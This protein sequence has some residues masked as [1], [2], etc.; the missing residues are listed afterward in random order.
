MTTV[1]PF[2]DEP[3][4]NPDDQ[5]FR[6]DVEGYEGPLDVL[7]QL[8]RTEKID[9]TRVAI[10]PL[11]EQ[12]LAFIARA[13]DLKIELAADFLVMAAWLAWLKSRLIAPDPSD[14]GADAEMLAEDLAFRLR[15]LE[16][17]REAAQQLFSRPLLGQGVFARGMPERGTVETTV[18]WRASLYDLL[19]AYGSV[20]QQEIVR[21][22]KMEKRPVFSIV[23]A[24]QV[25]ERIIG[26]SAQ[27]LPLAALVAAMPPGESRRGALAS[28][29]G[30]SLEM[31]REGSIRLRQSEPFA[32]LFVCRADI[33]LDP[34]TPEP[35]PHTPPANGAPDAGET[36]HHG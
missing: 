22:M 23:D 12:Y 5:A 33:A 20:R 13:K 25:L 3:R 10:L 28:T 21:T 16:S 34:N 11:A 19:N 8:A 30:A 29:F 32:P 36:L 2:E 7:L 31:A 24:R 1:D 26:S 35:P 9:L 17:M 15:R 14:E 6:V 4:Q 18:S 27:W